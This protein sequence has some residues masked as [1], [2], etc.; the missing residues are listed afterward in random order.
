MKLA[1]ILFHRESKARKLCEEVMEEILENGEFIVD[2]KILKSTLLDYIVKRLEREG[3]VV[4]Y[5]RRGERA[6]RITLSDEARQDIVKA[7][8]ALMQRLN[9]KP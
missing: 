9:Q 7:Y 5:R 4:V 8:T 1:C 3:V 2:S 6:V